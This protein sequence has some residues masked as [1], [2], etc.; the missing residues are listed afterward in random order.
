MKEL[1]K[2]MKEDLEKLLEHEKT[3]SYRESICEEYMYNL[4]K[5]GYDVKEY[6]NRY[7]KILI[8]KVER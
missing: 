4:S 8:E 6:K 1:S 5:R 3:C 7:Y 2:W